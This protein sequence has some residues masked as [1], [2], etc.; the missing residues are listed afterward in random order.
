MLLEIENQKPNTL[1]YKRANRGFGKQF[2]LLAEANR[3][4]ADL[5]LGRRAMTPP[6]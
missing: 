4:V 2:A 6:A 1:A 3:N 5:G